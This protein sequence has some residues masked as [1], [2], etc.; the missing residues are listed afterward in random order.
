MLA[1]MKTMLLTMYKYIIDDQISCIFDN[2]LFFR[3]IIES[4]PKLVTY[5]AIL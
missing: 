1:P 5:F 2:N 4:Y 3:D